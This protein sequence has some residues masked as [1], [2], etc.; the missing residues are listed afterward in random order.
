VR[1]A[2][3]LRD[4]GYQMA[5]LTNWSTEKF[6][7]TRGRYDIFDIFE[8]IVVSGEEGVVKPDPEIFQILLRR[9]NRKADECLFIDDSRPNVEAAAA[10]GFHTIVY[11]SP[12]QLERELERH[13]PAERL[14]T[15][16]SDTSRT[17]T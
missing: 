4:A 8:Q 13:L 10:L 14:R 9:I 5:G 17:N 1:I 16:P 7:E 15:V 6:I 12:E 2:R 3:K 11:V